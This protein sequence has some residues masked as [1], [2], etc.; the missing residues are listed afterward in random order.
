MNAPSTFPT[1]AQKRK[2][3]LAELRIERMQQQLVV[4]HIDFI[5]TGVEAGFIPPDS[6][7]LM[8]AELFGEAGEA[9]DE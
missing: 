3:T 6:A 8:L 9:A 4:A 2:M 5:A 7:P 1:T